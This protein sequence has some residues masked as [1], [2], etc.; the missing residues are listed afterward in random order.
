MKKILLLIFLFFV[1]YSYSQDRRKLWAGIEIGYGLS[2]SDSGGGYDVS[3]GNDNKMSFSLIKGI[4][5]YYI[6]PEISIGAGI[7]INSYTKPGL[8]TIPLWLDIRYHP[9][10]N[11]K[12]QINPGFGY[13]LVTSE[14]DLKGKLLAELSV[15]YK[16]F[17]FK[18]ISILPAIG[19]NFCNYSVEEIKSFSQS[20]HSLFMK[21]GMIF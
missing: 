3:Y 9:F 16:L 14:N 15:G 11:K 1:S 18:K 17:K 2:L 5:G 21:V 4:I 8:N 13:T 12:I 10:T 20:R 6:N 7:G 19:Y